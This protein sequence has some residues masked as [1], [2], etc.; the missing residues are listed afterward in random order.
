MLSARQSRNLLVLVLE[1][2]FAGNL[3]HE[4]EYEH[5]YEYEMG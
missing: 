1:E 4:H 5:E 3:E 2:A